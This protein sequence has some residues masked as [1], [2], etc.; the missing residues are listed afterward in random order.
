MK[1]KREISP[2]FLE[3]L[4]RR[5]LA[6]GDVPLARQPSL[7]SPVDVSV[8]LVEPVE[9]G[10]VGG[11]RDF[12]VYAV[13]GVD[14]DA[15]DEDLAVVVGAGLSVDGFE[16]VGGR[17]AYPRILGSPDQEDGLILEVLHEVVDGPALAAGPRNDQG[18]DVRGP[19]SAG[20]HGDGLDEVLVDVRRVDRIDALE[21]LLDA[22]GPLDDLE[23]QAEGDLL[24]QLRKDVQGLF[25]LLLWFLRSEWPEGAG[26]I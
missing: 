12:V 24:E 7:Q 25:F 20:G 2:W 3:D 17:G 8:V 6:A 11:V 15:V 4:G 13:A 5:S 16:F 21:N 22:L 1:K 9:D 10:V 26:G 23:A 14:V 18:V 19:G